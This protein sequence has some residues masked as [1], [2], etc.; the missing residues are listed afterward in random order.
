MNVIVSKLSNT[1]ERHPSEPRYTCRACQSYRRPE[2]RLTQRI[3]DEQPGDVS[4]RRAERNPNADFSRS[5][6]E[7]VGHHS[8]QADC[9]QEHPGH[10]KQ[11]KDGH[12]EP[13]LGD[14]LVNVLIRRQ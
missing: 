14:C 10:G 13:R 7:A 2:R 4:A 8:E 1:V 5:H 11:H 9:S 6:T 12:G 3:T